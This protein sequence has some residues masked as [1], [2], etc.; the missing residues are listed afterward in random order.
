MRRAEI[1]S[2]LGAMA[3]HGGALTDLNAL[4]HSLGYKPTTLE[5]ATAFGFP[6]FVR[7]ARSGRVRSIG[8]YMDEASKRRHWHI[9]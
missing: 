7:R 4:L 9:G 1:A 8:V 3:L 2:A 6:T 5:E